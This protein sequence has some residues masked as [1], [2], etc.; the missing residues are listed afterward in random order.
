MHNSCNRLNVGALARGAQAKEQEHYIRPEIEVK[1]GVRRAVSKR[2][3]GPSRQAIRIGDMPE[4]EPRKIPDHPGIAAVSGNSEGQVPSV[5]DGSALRVEV[6]LHRPETLPFE[7]IARSVV[8]RREELV[9]NR[10]FPSSDQVML[11][12]RS[13]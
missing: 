5:E 1:R 13:Q 9:T 10:P 4:A 11:E 8:A 12:S 3:S 7:V 2:V 6:V